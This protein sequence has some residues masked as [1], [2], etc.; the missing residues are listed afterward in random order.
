M[1]AFPLVVEP[2]MVNFPSDVAVEAD[3]MQT[4]YLL[5][6]VLPLDLLYWNDK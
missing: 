4:N 3:H 5:E 2:D 6:E 1:P